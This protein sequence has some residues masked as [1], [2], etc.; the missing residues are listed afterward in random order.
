MW[1]ILEILEVFVGSIN[2]VALKVKSKNILTI[3]RYEIV[4]SEKLRK[5]ERSIFEV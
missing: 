1:N 2:H 3:E 5:N 4:Y